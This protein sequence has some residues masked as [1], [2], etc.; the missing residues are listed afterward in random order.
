MK[1][2]MGPHLPSAVLD[3]R[4]LRIERGLRQEE[5]A[6]GVAEMAGE[7]GL[8]GV[9]WSQIESGRRPIPL[10]KLVPIAKFFY[11]GEN[12]SEFVRRVLFEQYSEV[13]NAAFDL[14]RQSAGMFSL[15]VTGSDAQTLKKIYDLKVETRAALMNLID[16]IWRD[17]KSAG[18]IPSW[19]PKPNPEFRK[20]DD[21]L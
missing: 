21:M 12:V 6:K 11:E 4:N 5:V 10:N 19:P 17:R 3:L 9:W 14:E 16:A 7:R 15:H 8:T 2:P 20:Q 1:P 18:E 13:A